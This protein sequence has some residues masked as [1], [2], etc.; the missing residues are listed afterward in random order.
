MLVHQLGQLVGYKQF[1]DWSNKHIADGEI[2]PGEN[3]RK[4]SI[5][6]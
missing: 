2:P 1:T 4:V 5:V 6:T 3:P